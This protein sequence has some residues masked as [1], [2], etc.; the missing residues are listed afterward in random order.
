M[1]NRLQNGNRFI[2]DNWNHPWDLPLG[3][4]RTRQIRIVEHLLR[5]NFHWFVRQLIGNPND[6]AQAAHGYAMC[7]QSDWLRRTRIL[8]NE[9]HIS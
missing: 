7:K 3:P 1:E 8:L 9:D 2:F 6:P 4:E 5:G